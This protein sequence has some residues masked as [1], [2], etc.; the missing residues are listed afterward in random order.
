[1][2]TVY[3]AIE[4]IRQTAT[5]ETDKGTKF[6]RLTR[7]FLKNDPLWKSK[8]AEV[9]LWENSPTRDSKDTGIDLVALDKEDHTYWAIQCKC[10]DNHA[11]L[12]YEEVATFYGKTGNKGRYPHTMIVTTAAKYSKHL[13]DIATYFC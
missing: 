6:E 1:M 3:D 2:T 10:W 9:W 5:S 12:D 11:T 8:L 13:D 7:F 4:H